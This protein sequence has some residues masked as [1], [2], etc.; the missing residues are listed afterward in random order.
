[1]TKYHVYY[2]DRDFQLY[3]DQKRITGSY[4]HQYYRDPKTNKKRGCVVAI[5]PDLD[6]L[7]LPEPSPRDNPPV[8][9][10]EFVPYIRVKYGYDAIDMPTI[11][12]G[13][14]LCN[15]SLDKFDK[16]LCLSLAIQRANPLNQ[17]MRVVPS[18]MEKFYKE[19]VTRAKKYFKGYRFF[20]PQSCN[21]MLW[22]I[23]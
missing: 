17:E 20:G 21:S 7:L 13:F 5:R 8:S 15:T 1:M 16:E 22:T 2:G 12:F 9:A 19:F 10:T 14:S 23:E 18:S 11:F 3:N 6:S 4:I